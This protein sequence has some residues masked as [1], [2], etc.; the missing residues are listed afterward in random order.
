MNEH[1][2]NED[3]FFI[4][5]ADT[6]NWA[7][8]KIKEERAR[9]DLFIEAANA[10]ID[11]L[12]SQIADEKEKCNNRTAFLL[13]KLDLF[14]D[15]APARETKTQLSLD[16]PAGKLVRKL[17]KTKFVRDDDKLIESL[18]DSEYVER[19]PSIKW[20]ELKKD[21]TVLDGIVMRKSTGEI[22]DGI[23]VEELPSEFD[24]R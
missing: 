4:E 2:F 7:I 13:L 17:S 11:R 5:N 22:L 20:G 6:A 1:E 14:L 18:K 19:K 23:T 15:D 12:K 9:R 24:V 10:Q 21:L 16:L 8:S 3:E